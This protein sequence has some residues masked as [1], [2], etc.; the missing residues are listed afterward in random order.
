MGDDWHS[1]A[2]APRRDNTGAPGD[3]VRN[4]GE[5]DDTMLA[6]LDRGPADDRP[7]EQLQVRLRHY[8]GRPFVDL[9]VWFRGD[10]GNYRPTSK[11][12]TVRGR[13][14]LEVLRALRGAAAQL[15]IPE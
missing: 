5:Q 2:A 9:R 3:R 10:D 15:G 13:E 12:S 6:A 11:G 14:L 4:Q 7:R 1:P 8:Q